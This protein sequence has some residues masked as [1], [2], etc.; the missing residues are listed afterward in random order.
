M[1]EFRN[2][3]AML[4]VD[5]HVEVFVLHLPCDDVEVLNVL[6]LYG[7]RHEQQQA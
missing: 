4:I 2:K 7:G 5:V 1:K 3:A 6:Y